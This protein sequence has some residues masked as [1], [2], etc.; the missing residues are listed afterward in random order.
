MKMRKLP[1]PA[2][3]PSAF[4]DYFKLRIQEA[5]V[6]ASFSLTCGLLGMGTGP[7]TPAP[8]CWIL[9]ASLFAALGSVAYFLA[10]SL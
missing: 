4:E 10:T 8:P 6:L 9:S 1:K 7:Q 2:L 5:K 3:R